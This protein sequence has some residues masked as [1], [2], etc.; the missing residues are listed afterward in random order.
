MK[1]GDLRRFRDDS[2]FPPAA[3]Q[4]FAGRTFLVLGIIDRVPG[5]R[6]GRVDLLVD[7]AVKKEWGYPWVEQNSE[8]LN[9]AG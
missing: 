1:P 8:V 3:T 6:A 4:S 9:E 5:K 7:G 2:V